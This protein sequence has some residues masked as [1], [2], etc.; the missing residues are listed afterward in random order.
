MKN[1]F[2]MLLLFPF[3]LQAQQDDKNQKFIDKIESYLLVKKFKEFSAQK[4]FIQIGETSKVSEE[5]I[6]KT[7]WSLFIAKSTIDC[8]ELEN[9][10][11]FNRYHFYSMNQKGKDYLNKETSFKK[12]NSFENLAKSFSYPVSVEFHMGSNNGNIGH[13]IAFNSK[14]RTWSA[15]GSTSQGFGN[16]SNHVDGIKGFC[17]YLKEASPL[18]LGNDKKSA[19]LFKFNSS[20]GSKI[21]FSIDFNQNNSYF[22]VSKN[23]IYPDREVGEWKEIQVVNEFKK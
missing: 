15:M 23:F 6:N 9:G 13:T 11:V 22:K 17:T 18:S 19:D 1:L 3:F 2:I 4:Y 7:N 14:N 12:I 8:N 5:N 10:L 21:S 16:A 20:V